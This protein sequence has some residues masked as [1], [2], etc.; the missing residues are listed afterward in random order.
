MN[1]VLARNLSIK[2][3]PVLT[4]AFVTWIGNGSL[5]HRSLSS[6]DKFWR[7]FDESFFYLWKSLKVFQFCLWII[8]CINGSKQSANLHCLKPSFDQRAIT[9]TALAGFAFWIFVFA[10]DAFLPRVFLCI[11][12]SFI[13]TLLYL[14]MGGFHCIC[15]DCINIKEH[16]VKHND[17]RYSLRKTP[18]IQDTF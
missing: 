3:T 4:F 15:Q 11:S 1:P 10:F 9:K 14:W 18:M 8:F 17:L 7:L 12:P 13:R 16:N 5:L 2:P 6:G